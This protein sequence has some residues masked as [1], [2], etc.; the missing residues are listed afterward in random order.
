MSFQYILGALPVSPSVLEL[1]VRILSCLS[2]QRRLTPPER[3]L[4]LAQKN[5]RVR[6]SR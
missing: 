3:A 5:S 1:T 6:C 4:S 2:V